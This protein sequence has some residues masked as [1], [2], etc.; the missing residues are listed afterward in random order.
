M[1]IIGWSELPDLSQVKTREDLAKLMQ[2]TYPDQNQRRLNNWIGQVWAFRDR[3]QSGDLVV[4][5]LKTR[6]SV[7]IGKVTGAYAYLT[8][9][10]GIR[11]HTRPV[12]W[13]RTDLPRPAAQRPRR[14]GCATRRNRSTCRRHRASPTVPGGRSAAT[15]RQLTAL[16]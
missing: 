3:I 9:E 7:A 2:E 11:I 15:V 12:Q 4:L 13:L 5:P 6:S 10:Q 1:A 16:P 8:D 14:T